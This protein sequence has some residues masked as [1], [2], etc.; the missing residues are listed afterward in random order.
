MNRAVKFVN[1]IKSITRLT[2]EFR[3][4]VYLYS[5]VGAT[6]VKYMPSKRT[7]NGRLKGNSTLT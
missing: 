7:I 6:R 3:F 4:H 5:A 2:H 1:Q